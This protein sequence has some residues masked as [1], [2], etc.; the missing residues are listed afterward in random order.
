MPLAYG[1]KEFGGPE[2][3]T[4]LEVPPFRVLRSGELLVKVHAAAINPLDVKFRKGLLQAKLPTELPGVMGREAAGVIVDK[5]PGV[6]EFQVG[7]PVF[8]L[9][10]GG[11]YAEFTRMSVEE[12]VGK[13]DGLSFVD[14]ATLAV[15]G[16]TAYD[17]VAELGLKRGET[18]LINGAGGGVGIFAA[19]LAQTSGVEVIGIASAGKAEFLQKYGMTAVAY[20]PQAV[21]RVRAIASSGVDGL[22]DVVGGSSFRELAA[23]VKDPTKVLTTFDDAVAAEVGGRRV[24]RSYSREVL[25]RLAELVVTHR[26]NPPVTDVIPFERA[27]DG[28]K[29]MESGHA[30]GKLVITFGERD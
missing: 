6:E 5:A 21:A 1:F 2:Q 22:Y 13:P 25:L 30:L 8:G 7:Q 11:A 28:L 9:A 12:A 19:Q 26:L 20:G 10:R 14:A 24:N 15:A 27:A 29:I 23:C 18:L 3:Q 16:A 4:M 17:G